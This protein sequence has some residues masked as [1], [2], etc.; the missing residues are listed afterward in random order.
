MLGLSVARHTDFPRGG[1]ASRVGRGVPP[2]RRPGGFDEPA[3]NRRVWETEK[4][5]CMFDEIRAKRDGIYAV[6]RRHK[7]E[8]PWVFGSCARKG[9]YGD[10]ELKEVLNG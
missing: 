4:N 9:Q 3:A 1:G 8:K 10:D 6:A 5:M 7:A 2:S